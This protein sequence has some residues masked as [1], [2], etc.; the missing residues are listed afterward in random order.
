MKYVVLIFQGDAQERQAA[1]PEDE[2]KQVHTDYQAINETPGVSTGPPPGVP[3][4]A[5]PCG[6]SR[7]GSRGAGGPQPHRSGSCPPNTAPVEGRQDRSAAKPTRCASVTCRCP[8]TWCSCSATVSA[9]STSA[10]RR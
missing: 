3:E 10:S 8:R 9:I 4:N 7:G 6:S 1:L 2:Q 5:P